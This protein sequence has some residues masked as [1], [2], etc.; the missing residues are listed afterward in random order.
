[1]NSLLID[2]RA[3]RDLL[4]KHGWCQ[5][6]TRNSDGQFCIAGAIDYAVRPAITAHPSVWAEEKIAREERLAQ[7]MQAQPQFPIYYGLTRWNDKPG[8]TQEDVID[9]LNN[10]IESGEARLQQDPTPN[11]G[12]TNG[13]MG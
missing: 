8:R 2:L 13:N 5:R 3:V 9:F 10:I 4:L 11:K 1:M 12:D 7:H 6:T